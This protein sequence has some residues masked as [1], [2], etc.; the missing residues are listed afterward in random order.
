MEFFFGVFDNDKERSLR[1]LRTEEE[2]IEGIFEELEE[3]LKWA[4]RDSLIWRT[5]YNVGDKFTEYLS[6][7]VN[8]MTFFHF[9][10]HHGDGTMHLVNQKIN[11]D[12]AIEL[13]NKSKKLKCVFLNGCDTKAIAEKLTNVPIVIGTKQ[14]VGDEMAMK[15][16]VKFYQ[17][18]CGNKNLDDFRDEQKIE[19]YF[20]QALHIFKLPAKEKA[21]DQVAG[22]E[23]NRGVVAKNAKSNDPID[24]YQIVINREA[25]DFE[26]RVKYLSDIAS[27]P[28][29]ECFEEIIEEWKENNEF[30]ATEHRECGDAFYRY[31]PKPI[32]SYLKKICPSQDD[33]PAKQLGIARFIELQKL[34][35][36]FLLF[37]KYCG[38]SLIWEGVRKEQITIDDA[39]KDSMREHLQMDWYEL[40]PAK[41]AEGI[42][43]LVNMYELLASENIAA[44]FI[45]ESLTR[46]KKQQQKLKK[47][48]ELFC[49]KAKDTEQPHFFK[50]EDF[51]TLFV[52]EWVFLKNYEYTSFLDSTYTRYI[53]QE[54]TYTYQVRKFPKDRGGFDVLE[55]IPIPKQLYDVFSIQLIE[56]GHDIKDTN[57]EREII[58]LSPFYVD[59]NI[60]ENQGAMNGL[61][62][63]IL[64]CLAMYLYEDEFNVT[65]EILTY[66]VVEDEKQ[67]R[68]NWKNIKEKEEDKNNRFFAS[69][70]LYSHINAFFQI[71]N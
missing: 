58:N 38:F 42:D 27:F 57:T 41:I 66:R 25:A 22:E 30:T 14:N 6:K 54:D 33:N 3:S 4:D 49:L 10:G 64:N 69:T 50:A 68:H 48:S 9:S 45:K 15:V 52:K 23:S 18:L 20:N 59:S 7:W 26:N 70:K 16:A 46:F 36:N 55:T 53:V 56:K 32:S 11:D 5:K 13:L 40:K 8:S 17:L 37:F 61:D 44:N 2:Q 28:A 65:K 63:A 67:E 12:A 34:Y 29:N 35:F 24:F 31:F 43:L 39:L 51:L 47:F 71:L 19:D 1:H 60:K 21:E 62:K